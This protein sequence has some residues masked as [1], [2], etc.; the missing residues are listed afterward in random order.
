MTAKT[1]DILFEIIDTFVKTVVLVKP[2]MYCQSHKALDCLRAS[3]VAPYSRRLR[4]KKLLWQQFHCHD[5][6]WQFDG[7]LLPIEP[8]Q[9]TAVHWL[10]ACACKLGASLVTTLK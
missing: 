9:G 8:T 4:L 1:Y 7:P 5:P 6:A 10:K 2:T 3:A